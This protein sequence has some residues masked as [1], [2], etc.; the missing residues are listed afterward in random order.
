MVAGTLDGYIHMYD[1]RNTETSLFSEKAHDTS[2]SCVKFISN[3]VAPGTMTANKENFKGNYLTSTINSNSNTHSSSNDQTIKRSNSYNNQELSNI[4]NIY[5]PEKGYNSNSTASLNQQSTNQ[6][7]TG[8]EF[9]LH[10]K[11]STSIVSL[12]QTPAQANSTNANSSECKHYFNL[13]V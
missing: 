11:K 1:L 12:N 4:H 5:S 7:A 6:F 8:G 13:K 3:L 9:I 2:V 10:K